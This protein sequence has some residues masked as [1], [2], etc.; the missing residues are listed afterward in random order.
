[1]VPL[2]RRP[3]CQV[4]RGST[5]QETLATFLQQCLQLPK[6]VVDEMLAEG[7]AKMMT[8]KT[9]HMNALYFPGISTRC[10]TT[11]VMIELT[12][13]SRPELQAIGL[14][15]M[16]KIESKAFPEAELGA[17]TWCWQPQGHWS[18]DGLEKLLQEHGIDTQE[19]PLGSMA[20]LR[21][22]LDESKYAKLHIR[23]GKL[24]RNIHIIKVWLCATILSVEYVLTSRGKIQGGKRERNHKEGP[25][26]LRMRSDQDWKQAAFACL[27]D[28]LG[29]DQAF[30][31]SSLVI[32]DSSHTLGEEI[33]Y[34]RS[35]PGLKTVY[36]M[37]TVKCRV[38][39]VTNPDLSF[40]GLPDGNDF[41]VT[42]VRPVRGA[43][44]NARGGI[45]STM[46]F[47][48]PRSRLTETPDLV[49][50][51]KHLS[52]AAAP[53]EGWQDMTPIAKRQLAPPSFLSLAEDDAGSENE[54]VLANL[55]RDRKTDWA[56]A[57]KAA[58]RILDR[59]YNLKNF[60]DDC[61]A[62]F[63]E[64][65]LYTA[66]GE[67]G[68]TSSGRSTVE[69]YQ[70]TMGALFAVFWI[71]RRKL[72]GAESFCFGVDEEWEP[73]SI[74]SMRPRRTEEEAEKR[75]AFF[76]EVDWDKIED[77]LRHAGLLQ[78]D[79]EGHDEDRTLAMLVLTAIHDIMK[80]GALLPRV[81]AKHAPFC[82]YKA[83]DP[84]NDHDI[85]LGYVLQF[86][87]F[88]LPSFAGLAK[89]LQELIRFSQCKLEYN[90]GWLVQAEAPPGA[91]FTKF[92]ECTLSE[93]ADPSAVAFYFVHWLTDLAGAEP[94]PQEGCEKFVLKFPRRVLSSFLNSFGIVQHLAGKSETQ[95]F[96]DY[97]VWRW[98]DHSPSL[99]PVR[100]GPGSIAALRLV[101]M[102]QGDSER[103][104]GALKSLPQEDLEVLNTELA[105]T[106]CKDQAY[107]LERQSELDQ[108]KGGPAILIYYAPA[109]MQ[110]AG[111]T[112]PKLALRILAEIFRQARAMW[113][114]SSEA[115]HE[116][117]TVRIDVL[118]EL[119]VREIYSLGSN[120]MW[121]LE[122]TSQCDAEAVK[123]SMEELSSQNGTQYR[124]L[125][126]A[127]RA[128]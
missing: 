113:P 42:R 2:Q 100:E 70:R 103:I 48:K 97:L 86:H 9:N 82:G 6:Y 43:R 49:Y 18:E 57:R 112:E 53:N 62:A 17:A 95:V 89:P 47:W 61:V 37:H 76:A 116:T 111:K 1:L 125:R 54:L 22:E 30:M 110:K 66:I 87:P 115:Q 19:F 108:Q 21:D 7:S 39:D 73:L 109:L 92:K 93:G 119:E 58:T 90:M 28:K 72:G 74:R 96:E 69:E 81:E 80:M 32:N 50:F 120:Q 91:L 14:P 99:G 67:E 34:S 121:A 63:P 12:D 65:L 35:Y 84:I 105:R 77:L 20:E 27:H 11:E 78:N 59:Q 10:V 104:L 5:W 45:I 114:L 25:V 118:K 26:T 68:P 126:L 107:L 64:L 40:I 15:A 106:G 52:L 88:A 127:D 41:S 123:V 23:A 13:P 8:Q 29:L 101:V 75:R 16:T 122:Q 3:H 46:W 55:M 31:N 51:A 124:I 83:G 38:K 94:Y 56:R 71:M 33:E 102:A 60:H 98:K 24:V 85:A 79:I 117:V 4:L 44:K 128:S 36:N